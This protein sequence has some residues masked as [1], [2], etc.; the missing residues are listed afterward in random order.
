M[1][2]PG[3]PEAGAIDIAIATNLRGESGHQ[4][5]VR[6]WRTR[7][8]GACFPARAPGPMALHRTHLFARV[9]P[10]DS[11][12]KNHHRLKGLAHRTRPSIGLL[13]REAHGGV[14]VDKKTAAKAM[15]LSHDPMILAITAD[16]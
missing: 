7:L 5:P 4:I 12:A 3:V 1:A 11:L 9:T 8:C 6:L 15:C 10:H 2:W 14:F 13:K 16:A